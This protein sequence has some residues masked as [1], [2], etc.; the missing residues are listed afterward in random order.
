[1]GNR[2]LQAK[3]RKLKRQR[4]AWARPLSIRSGIQPNRE[5]IR[6]YQNTAKGLGL[7]IAK[8]IYPNVAPGKVDIRDRADEIL[9]QFNDPLCWTYMENTEIRIRIFFNSQRNKNIVQYVNWTTKMV[10]I[11]KPYLCADDAIYLFSRELIEWT[12]V[13]PLF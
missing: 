10:Y 9:R 5:I 4:R 2:V 13:K 6:Q 12:T 8:A 1:M 7:E 11:S 3:T